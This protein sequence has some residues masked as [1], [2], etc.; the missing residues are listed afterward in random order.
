MMPRA[1]VSNLTPK[2]II[3]IHNFML[4]SLEDCFYA[5]RQLHAFTYRET[6]LRMPEVITVLSEV[7]AGVCGEG[8]GAQSRYY[9]Q[10]GV[11]ILRLR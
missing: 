1:E 4:Q 5:K 8:V 11:L 3:E 7:R 2:L 9:W 6:Y 10:I